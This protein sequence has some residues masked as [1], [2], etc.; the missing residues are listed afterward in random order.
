LQAWGTGAWSQKIWLKKLSL[1]SNISFFTNVT[2]PGSRELI[3]TW[4]SCS[5][6]SVSVL[7]PPADHLMF[8][9]L[10]NIWQKSK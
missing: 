2:K 9:I 10:T 5:C 6:L 3:K 4:L 8:T 1:S 7:V